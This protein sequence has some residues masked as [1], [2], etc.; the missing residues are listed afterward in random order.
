MSILNLKSIGAASPVCRSAN[1]FENSAQ[2][3]T[4]AFPG[5][6]VFP[7]N[8]ATTCAGNGAGGESPAL[9]PRV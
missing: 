8:V 6:S 3:R 5:G 2:T 9:Q 1:T 7:L 4:G